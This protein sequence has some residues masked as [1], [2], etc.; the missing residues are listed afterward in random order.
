MKV[1]DYVINFLADK[2]TEYIF[3][4][5]GG[6]IT[7]LIDSADKNK[8]VKFVQVYHEQTAS[9]AAEGYSRNSSRV[10]VAMATSGPGATNMITGIADAFFDSI[11]TIYITGQVNT[12]EFKYQKKVRQQG[13]QETDIV[14]IVKPITKYAKLID[15][16]ELIRYEL[17]KAFYIARSG[18][19]GPVLL[20]LPMDVQRQNI[21]SEKLK[22]F[23]LPRKSENK[24]NFKEIGSLLKKS[25]RP[26][27]LAGG[28]VINSKAQSELKKFA[29]NNQIP[30]VCSL[31]GKGGFPEDHEL[32]VGMIGSY[33]N[34]CANIVLANTDLLLAVGSR[35]DT[36]QVGTNLPS[37]MR[38]GK[39]V[40]VD[41]DSTE[42]EGN[43]I[44]GRIEVQSDAKDFLETLNQ[45]FNLNG[46]ANHQDWL[47]YV[48]K[49][50]T[51]YSQKKEVSRNCLNPIP[52]DLMT[53]LNSSSGKG[54]IFVADVGQNQMFA[55]QGLIIKDQQQFYTSGGMA[56][57]GYSIPAAIGASFA[58]KKSKLIAITGDGGFH[59]SLQSLMLLSQY[60]LP[61]KVIVLNNQS[62][63]MI[64][65]FQ[66]LYFDSNT[67][68]TTKKGGYLVPSIESIAKAYGI[69]YLKVVDLTKEKRKFLKNI[70]S[71]KPQII[72]IC[73]EDKTTVV[74]KLEVN[75]PIE[76][77]SPRL[78][79]KEL[80]SSMLI[81]L[82]EEDSK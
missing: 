8:K 76:N 19:P 68:A 2:G 49:I 36:R 75:Q 42:L 61:I 44:P 22:S 21:I 52:Y 38:E 55:G 65:Q 34:R 59:I 25:K 79:R 14:E 82:L 40:Q 51:Q 64:V 56:P 53:I 77:M 7:H 1:S 50:K 12:Y 72:E 3:G 73:I 20:D 31:M 63:G 47:A 27:I 41:I 32:F 58:D 24:N 54:E 37:F 30:V 5:I 62:L 45:S 46:D 35:L 4:Y 60:K 10:G 70:V 6:A 43:R 16:P 23:S 17:E 9:I 18:R 26:L 57:M 71:K 48:N 80:A 69:D 33:G 28:G 11:P 67:A 39:I 74:P 66:D 13:F 81:D 78:S 15:R 29:L